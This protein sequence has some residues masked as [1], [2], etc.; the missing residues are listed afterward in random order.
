MV[1]KSQF[2]DARDEVKEDSISCIY[3]KIFI[4]FKKFLD[5]SRPSSKLTGGAKQFG[6]ETNPDNKE[7]NQNSEEQQKQIDKLDQKHA[8]FLHLKL[9]LDGLENQDSESEYLKKN[10]KYF[11][12]KKNELFNI[13]ID[14]RSLREN[15]G[16]IYQIYEIKERDIFKPQNILIQYQANLENNSNMTLYFYKLYKKQEKI[17]EKERGNKSFIYDLSKFEFL[18]NHL[19]KK[20]M[21]IF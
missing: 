3:L 15:I 12:D 16:E 13:D 21:E 20:K 4:L 5:I 7:T 19:T 6:G 11:V 14:E 8:K 1:R 18:I 2:H 9:E 17:A 10:Y